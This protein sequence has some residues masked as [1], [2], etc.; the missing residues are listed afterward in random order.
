MSDEST[1]AESRSRLAMFGKEFRKR[2][3]IA[4]SD[5]LPTDIGITKRGQ[6][7]GRNIAG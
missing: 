7:S 3:H 2:R 5:G 1:V 4:L 6:R